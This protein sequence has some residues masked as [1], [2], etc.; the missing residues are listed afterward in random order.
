MLLDV[1]N[2]A[3]N[4][5][6]HT[7]AAHAVLSNT[8]TNTIFANNETANAQ[9]HTQTHTPSRANTPT[10]KAK[11][12]AASQRLSTPR[13]KLAYLHLYMR[14]QHIPKK[15]MPLH[16]CLPNFTNIS[17]LF[18]PNPRRLFPQK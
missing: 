14:M 8:P 11:Q 6:T 18:F 16:F 7:Q 12:E 17:T 13:G 10:P 2:I 1:Q 3:N 4:T 9:T 5:P 15:L